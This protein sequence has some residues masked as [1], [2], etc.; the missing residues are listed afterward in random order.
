MTFIPGYSA[1]ILV[2]DFALSAYVTDIALPYEV[3]MLDVTTMVDPATGLPT[4]AKRFIPGQNTSTMTIKGFLD[5]DTTSD[6]QYDQMNDWTG[7]EAVTYAPNGM[8]LGSELWMVSALKGAFTIGA[9]TTTPVGFDLTCQTDGPTDFGRSLL[10][11]TAITADGSGTGYDGGA[12]STN[13]GVAHL[14]STAFSGLSGNVVI[15]EDSANNSTWATIGT[16][17]TVAGLTQQRLAIAGTIRRY[18][19]YS[20]DVTGTGSNTIQVGLARR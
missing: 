1:R 16:F 19:R 18:T 9:T 2:G 20:T 4:K 10:D 7:A 13:G 12:Q 11:L 3:A 17:T 15:V 6:M 14:H 5:P 8:A